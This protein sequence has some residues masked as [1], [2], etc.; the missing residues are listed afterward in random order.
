MN[1]QSWARLPLPCRVFITSVCLV[2]PEIRP[3]TLS[4][5]TAAHLGLSVFPFGTRRALIMARTRRLSRTNNVDGRVLRK[6]EARQADRRRVFSNAEK[7]HFITKW[8]Q[9]QLPSR[10]FER[11][12]G[13]P[14][15]AISK[16]RKQLSALQSAN[17][18]GFST[19]GAAHG[20]LEGQLMAWLQVQGGWKADI[21]RPHRALPHASPADAHS[22]QACNGQHA[23]ASS[24]P[25]RRL[26]HP[27][28]R[29]V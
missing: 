27:L 10:T 26:P 2:L 23:T 19:K 22:R 28:H 1:W 16:W 29:L 3:P 17:P 24:T 14:E 12:H 21:P 8:E 5:R 9:C 4:H 15:K 18:L 6:K 20:R 25:P 7:I 13:L 11:T